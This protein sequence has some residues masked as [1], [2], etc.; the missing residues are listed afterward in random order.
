MICVRTGATC[1][2]DWQTLRYQ[3]SSPPGFWS[4]LGIVQTSPKSPLPRRVRPVRV[5]TVAKQATGEMISLTGHIHAEDKVNLSFPHRRADDRADGQRRRYRCPRRAGGR[6][7]EE[8]PARNALLAARANLVSARGLLTR[9]QNDYERQRSLLDRG[10]T[11]FVR[12]DQALQEHLAAQAQ[13]TRRRRSST[14]RRTTSVYSA[15]QV[16]RRARPALSSRAR[17][18][19]RDR[20]WCRSPTRRPRC[21]LRGAGAGDAAS[22]CRTRW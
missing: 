7:A 14:R 16:I 9:A 19:R 13:V 3:S 15:D 22:P 20:W 10:F 4:S 8:E 18:C 2:D 12:Y 1:W 21:D 11:T 6:P 5:V 17:W